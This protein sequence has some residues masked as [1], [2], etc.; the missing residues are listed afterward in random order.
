MTQALDCHWSQLTALNSGAIAILQLTG[1]D[2]ASVLERLT[3]FSDW[4]P[5]VLRHVHFGDIDDGLA[6]LLNAETAQIM[7]HGGPRVLQR[8]AQELASL[9]AG[10]DP[11]PDPTSVFPEAADAFEARMLES[12]AHAASPAA[13][14]LLLAQ[15][16]RWRHWRAQSESHRKTSLP[17]IAER[18]QRWNRLLTPAT[19]AVVGRPNVGKS[20]LGNRMLGQ[21]AS[22]VADLPGTT[23]DW[24]AGF[25]NLR[26]S[27]GDVVVR[28]LDTPGIRQS[29]D[30]I[31]QRAIELAQQVI[32][33]ADV[34]VTVRDELGEWIEA[35]ALPR[36]PDVWVVNKCDDAAEGMSEPAG[37]RAGQ[38]AK[39]PLRISA[40]HGRNLRALEAAVL[41]CL[42][43]DAPP[44]PDEL[45]LLDSSQ[46]A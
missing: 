12:L 1:P 15:P 44:E 8:L 29:D 28:W 4:K 45:W 18:S 6:V 16:V 40:L 24:V 13:M 33:S 20:T 43:L 7:P 27:W 2:A 42:G 31:E 46:L 11:V 21:A 35:A 38:S 25:A 22:L 36:K 34:V 17:R 26:A 30:P 32:A 19:V 5:G 3:S 9:G 41:R 23:R 39:D 14:D 10:H 37:D